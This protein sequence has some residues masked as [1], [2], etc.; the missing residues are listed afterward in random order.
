MKIE[1]ILSFF[2]AKTTLKATVLHFACFSARKDEQCLEMIK[3][4]VPEPEDSDHQLVLQKNSDG[5]TAVCLAAQ[6]SFEASV[7]Y[8]LSFYQCPEQANPCDIEL[9]YGVR[10]NN[11]RIMEQIYHKHKSCRWQVIANESH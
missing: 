2:Q 6:R 1:Y 10:S 8:L 4:F 7:E 3:I 11:A 9:E 5:L